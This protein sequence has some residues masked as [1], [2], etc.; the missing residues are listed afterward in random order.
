MATGCL[1]VTTT[2]PRMVMF[3]TDPMT[4]RMWLMAPK[5][6]GKSTNQIVKSIL[7]VAAAALIMIDSQTSSSAVC[8]T[9]TTL[10]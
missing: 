6:T 9:G 7:M 3:D 8:K 5:K 10:S 4:H 2:M 1:Y